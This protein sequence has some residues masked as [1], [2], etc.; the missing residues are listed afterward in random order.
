MTATSFLQHLATAR[1][2]AEFAR[3]AAGFAILQ[4]YDSV[5]T[6]GLSSFQRDT[7]RKIESDI[8]GIDAAPD[9]RTAL[10]AMA[11]ALQF[12]ESAGPVRVGR[13]ATYTAL[14]MYGQAL[15]SEGE[16]AMAAKVFALAGMDTELD[17]ETWLAAESRLMMGRA[18][19]MCADWEMAQIAYRRASQL[20][21]EAGDL[22][23]AF[24]AQIGEAN[25]LWSRGNLQG[26][27]LRLTDIARQARRSCPSV[28]P[29]VTLALAGVANMSGEYEQAI[30]LAFGILETLE[31]DD[32]LKYQTLV[33]LASFLS[34]YGLPAVASAALRVVQKAAPERHVRRHATLNLFFLAAHHENAAAFEVLRAQLASERLTPRQQ[35]QFALFTA[36]GCRR[37]AR[38]AEARSAAQRAIELANRYEH[39]QLVFEAETELSDIMRAMENASSEIPQR[40]ERSRSN[41]VAVS[42]DVMP[43]PSATSIGWDSVPAEIREVA[44]SLDFM[45]AQHGVG[46]S[47]AMST[48]MSTVMSGAR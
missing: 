27:R 12:W 45:A 48:A 39:F 21:R 42:D 47:T 18:Y 46:T 35:A 13:K 25:L 37:F 20:G 7:L 14:I 44:E 22:S 15:G 19:R 2:D 17:G 29:R 24:R 1:S 8:A 23:I 33:D 32:E 6:N 4:I 36:Q 11:C 9:V 16:W 38:F 26:A 3:T 5:K 40:P 41:I 34:D 31:E 10:E 30:S 28:V 43:N